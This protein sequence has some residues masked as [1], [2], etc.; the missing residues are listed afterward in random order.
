MARVTHMARR[1]ATY[2][3]RY[4]LPLELRGKPVPAAW[5]S[6]LG[7]LVSPKHPGAPAGPDKFKGELTRSLETHDEKTAKGRILPLISWTEHLCSAARRVLAE[8]PRASLTPEEAAA[9]ANDYRAMILAIDEVVRKDGAWRTPLSSLVIGPHPP[10]PR[11][12]DGP[13]EPG[14][15]DADLADYRNSI[16]A[17]EAE[18]K[19]AMA[20]KRPPALT[21]RM[22]ALMLAEANV[23]LPD[24][25]RRDVELDF[26]AA[27]RLAVKDLTARLDGD[28]V[29]TPPI[30]KATAALSGAG[31]ASATIRQAFERWAA[32]D[33]AVRLV[34]DDQ[35]EMP[36]VE[37]AHAV[38]HLV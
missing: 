3:F 14:M 21:R 1:G 34:D 37:T 6:D 17:Q 28:V 18:L 30:G 20:T 38:L 11:P 16:A 12:E 8:G 19:H 27:E 33:G 7:A 4:R 31:R 25:E 15:S 2:W 29:P 36:R 9:L 26:L 13:R 24:I 22:V 32:I 35:V 5:P 10:P 23:R